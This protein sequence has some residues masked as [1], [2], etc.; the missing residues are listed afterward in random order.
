MIGNPARDRNVLRAEG[1]DPPGPELDTELLIA[2]RGVDREERSISGGHDPIVQIRRFGDWQRLVRQIRDDEDAV[3]VGTAMIDAVVELDAIDI[4]K[5]VVR[6]RLHHDVARPIVERHGHAIVREHLVG[7]FRHAREHRADVEDAGDRAQEL[8][9][10]LEVG[11]PVT[12][13]R[14]AAGRL[15]ETL[16]RHGNRDVVGDALREL[17]VPL[18]VC[19]RTAGE[20]REHA[21]QLAVG[22]HRHSQPRPQPALA[23]KGVMEQDGHRGIGQAAV[24]AR[25]HRFGLAFLRAGVHPKARALVRQE[26]EVRLVVDDHARDDSAQPL[27]HV[28]NIERSANRG[29][30]LVEHARSVNFRTRS[31][32]RRQHR[33]YL[34]AAVKFDALR[35]SKDPCRSLVREDERLPPEST[36]AIESGRSFSRLYVFRP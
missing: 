27:K 35:R 18:G 30:E 15:G 3:G 33:L 29:Q 9:R 2:R 20:Q 5:V 21:N 12:F 24:L 31:I 10:A 25:A 36:N 14:G 16:M 13:E 17:E 19:V 34:F 32:D 22:A 11:R 6:P 7:D 1:V 4:R 8:D 23:A 28:T 26:R